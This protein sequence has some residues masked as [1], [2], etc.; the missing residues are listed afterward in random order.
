MGMSS[1]PV[2][3][4]VSFVTGITTRGFEEVVGASVGGGAGA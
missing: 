4:G 3:A 2:G 1:M